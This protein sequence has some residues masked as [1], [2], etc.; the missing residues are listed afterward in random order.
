MV[1]VIIGITVIVLLVI[2]L[3]GFK[4][5]NHNFITIWD[6]LCRI[7][8]LIDDLPDTKTFNAHNEYLA[9]GHN[10]IL[11]KLD[12]QCGSRSHRILYTKMV[13]IQDLLTRVLAKTA[14]SLSAKNQATKKIEQ[15]MK[16]LSNLGKK[17][18]GS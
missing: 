11:I 8:A 2:I 6:E 7:H 12:D 17:R 3:L 18:R 14:I 15:A 13:E 16:D 1:N 5:I 9:E 10:K 4:K